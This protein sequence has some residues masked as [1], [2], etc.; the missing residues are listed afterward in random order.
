MTGAGPGPQ[1]AAFRETAIAFLG[2]VLLALLSLRAGPSWR[3]AVVGNFDAWQGLW[4]LDH[5]ERALRGET[6]LYR[7]VRVWA[8]EG[9]SLVLHALSPALTI[10]GALLARL[11]GPYLAWDVLVVLCLALSATALYRLARRAGATPAGAAAGAAV[12][13][14]SPLLTARV[15][16][17]HLNLLPLGLV[18]VAL[19]GLIAAF[20]SRAAARLA[21]LGCA[22]LALAAVV[23]CDYYLALLAVIGVGVFGL[24]EL[25]RPAYG[26]SRAS[27]L[28]VL[29]GTAILALLLSAPLLMRLRA[30]VRSGPP[31]GHDPSRLAVDAAALVV[32][33]PATF[34]SRLVRGL[35]GPPTPPE[36]E[37]FAFL[38]LV[39]LAAL[40]W[41]LARARSPLLVRTAAAG[42]GA[43]L[44][45]FGPTLVVSGRD[46]GIPMPYALLQTLVPAVRHGGGANRFLLLALLPLGLGVAIATTRLLRWETPA[47][48]LVLSAAALLLVVELAPADPGTASFPLLPPDP[49][50][51]AV[52]RDGAKG[53]VL[54]VD[55]G[56]PGLYRQLRHGRPQTFGYLSRAPRGP[57]EER[58]HDPL[59]GPILDPSR[60]SRG[61]IPKAAAA[62]FLRERWGVRFVVGPDVSPFRE[63]AA[64]FGFPLLAR[65]AG[66]SVAYRVPEGT[67]APRDV[68]D[69]SASDDV[70]H[71]GS[72]FATGLHAPESLPAGAGR[73]TE[74]QASLFLP[75]SPGNWELALAAPRPGPVPVRI[76]WGRRGAETQI[77]VGERVVVP[78]LVAPSDLT[79]GGGLSVSIEARAFRPAGDPQVVGVFLLRLEREGAKVRPAPSSRATRASTAALTA[80]LWRG[81]CR[82]TYPP[83]R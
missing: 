47:R 76:R 77:E 23:Y 3:E 82:P 5:V 46:T 26:R 30:E 28:A 83:A 2:A 61:G 42:G 24:G 10:P 63:R 14:F 78:I 7:S 34:A 71:E 8:P 15:A 59:L 62:F 65:S 37:R 35:G 21:G 41:A 18:P 52:A 32:P 12:F 74:A 19:E 13:G 79:P 20:A 39:P 9:A 38:G 75:A 81:R 16:A 80:A 70:L 11:T 54:D 50:M 6:P 22:A 49:A 69:F 17:G 33:G 56:I 36:V 29:A 68:V 55:P 72:V 64:G 60:P 25:A 53:A 51:V 66:L 67:P 1:G 45:S 43:L 31:S 73:W 27:V 57:F 44:L 4:N 40:G 48:R 58:L